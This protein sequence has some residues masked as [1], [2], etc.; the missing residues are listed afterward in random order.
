MQRQLQ[1]E[2]REELGEPQL[3]VY[4]LELLPQDGD[5]V[6]GRQRRQLIA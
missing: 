5:D 3:E 2:G 1:R 6:R 4:D